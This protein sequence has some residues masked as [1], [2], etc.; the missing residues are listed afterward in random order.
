M[1]ARA[2]DPVPLELWQVL[3]EEYSSQGGLLTPEYES[4]RRDYQ[5]H[6]RIAGDAC[7][8]APGSSECNTALAQ[9]EI[10]GRALLNALTTLLHRARRS[11]LC[12]SGG[13]IRSA[14]FGLGV[15]QAL[16]QRSSTAPNRPPSL[17]GEFNYLSTVSGGGYLGGWFSAWAKWQPK[18]VAGVID[19]LSAPPQSKV[20]P[21]PPALQHLRSFSNYMDPKLGL[22]SADTWSLATTMLRNMVL[23]WFVILPLLVAV[24]AV[25]RFWLSLVSAS[26]SC[27]SGWLETPLWA[28]LGF[29]AVALCFFSYN[30]PTFGN[31]RGSQRVILWTVLLPFCFS[32]ALL[33]LGFAWRVNAGCGFPVWLHAVKYGVAAAIVGTTAGTLLA[34][35]R[36]RINTSQIGAALRKALGSLIAAALSG[37]VAALL[38]FAL[39]TRFYDPSLGRI[40]NIAVYACFAFPALVTIF[41]LAGILLFGLAS[42]LTDEE[43]REWWSRCNAW[44]MIVAATWIVPAVLVIFGPPIFLALGTRLKL[45]LS[46]AGGLGGFLAS[47]LGLS[48]GGTTPAGGS[49]ET[50]LGDLKGLAF[51]KELAV[52]LAAP[53]F[54]AL[55]M[56]LIS[57]AIHRLT[58]A[59]PAWLDEASW[60][61]IPGMPELLVIGAAL[62]A[63]GLWS[64]TIDVNKFSLHGMYRDRLV[65]AYLGASNPA[66]NPNPFT[67]FDPKDDFPV[68]ELR[69]EKPLHILNMC[70]NLVGGSNLAWQE[71]KAES[72]TVSRLHAGSFRVGYRP[73]E[74]YGERKG[75]SLGTCVAISGAAASP[76]MGYHSSPLVTLMMTLFNARLGWWLGN[77]GVPGNRT[78]RRP[79]PKWA[80]RA[81]VDEALGLTTDQ[82]DWIYLSD[83][84]HFENLAIY[85]MVLRRCHVIV[86]SD[87]GADPDYVFED[88]GNAVE[89]IRVDLGVPIHFPQEISIRS[90]KSDGN[91]HCA[92]G[93]ICYSA[94]DPGAEDGLI[95]YLK[96]CLNANEP[97]DVMNYASEDTSFPQQPTSDQWFDEGQFESYRQLGWHAVSEI[98]GFDSGTMT[99]AEFAAR[100]QQYLTLPPPGAAKP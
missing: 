94:V 32:A 21:E 20:D 66:R 38:A 26:G 95:I 11:A 33:A 16:A 1:A 39:A 12:F 24:I 62:A 77:P 60:A 54:L 31:L 42:K 47:R 5:E 18:S 58:N 49:N 44:L 76:N 29:G 56:V 88:L 98:A 35:W 96:P 48:T 37:A 57:S 8:R 9:K 40:R 69:S 25:P 6:S 55:L 71:R 59:I 50:T 10:A 45:V 19:D 74:L 75:I 53:A 78:W 92:I 84:G 82:S 87:A 14:T 80:A 64:L 100:A 43:D 52:R 79:G 4:I 73:A 93:R 61:Q 68:H 7:S 3:E 63:A 72:F 86:V 51:V 30:L 89:K 67:G 83:G 65:R 34:F 17:L 22:L 46:S 2:N 23:N 28:G 27:G 81:F 90:A 99:L 91:K 13:G 70:L 97:A 36:R 15:L 41:M 85:E